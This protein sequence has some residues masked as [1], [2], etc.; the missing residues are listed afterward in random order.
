VWGA[1]YASQAGEGNQILQI[2]LFKSV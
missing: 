2:K 1:F